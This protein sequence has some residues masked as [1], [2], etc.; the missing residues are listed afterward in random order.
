MQVLG[1]DRSSYVRGGERLFLRSGEIHYFRVPRAEWRDRLAKFKASGG[2]CVA[3]YVPW[4]IHEP[5][6]GRF[7]FADP[8]LD[9]EAFLRLCDEMGLWVL[10]RPGPYQYSELSYDGLPGWLCENYPELRARNV[11]GKDF[12]VSSISY[13][14]PQF[15]AKARRWF[16]EVVPRLARHQTTRGGAVAAVQLDNELMG[17]HEWFGSWDYH[18]EAMGLGREEGRWPEFLR[19]R[20]GSLAALNEAWDTRLES[21]AKAVPATA[22]RDGRSGE[23]R[24]VKDYQDCYFA[25]IADFAETLAQWLRAEGIEVPLV[26]NSANPYMNSYF[27]ETVARLGNSQFLLGSDHYY[28]LSQDWDQNNPTP[29]YAT[30]CFYSNEMLR[31]YGFPPTIFELPGGSLSDFPPITASDA[32]CCYLLNVALGMK[33]YNYYIFTGGV[34]RPNTG[35]TGEL[36]DYGAALSPTGE[37]RPLYYAQQELA[38][39][40]EEH[41]WLAGAERVGDCRLGLV[42]EYSRAG[43]Y[44]AGTEGLPFPCEEA[45]TFMRKGAMMTAFCASASP[46]LADLDSDSLLADLQTPLLVPAASAMPA[47]VQRR[48]V[49]FLEAGGKLLLTP[50]VPTLDEHFRPCRILADFLGA[51][52]EPLQAMAPLLAAFGVRNVFVNGGLLATPQ[53][54]AGATVTAVEE[55]SGA[56][57]GWEQRLPGGGVASVLGVHWRQAKREHEEMLRRALA[58]LGWQARVRGDNPNVWTSLRS[59]GQRSMLFLMNLFTAPMTVRAEFCDPATG[60]WVDTGVHRL[61]PISVQMWHNGRSLV[62]PLPPE[63]R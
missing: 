34:N 25:A 5:E 60:A 52:Q 31:H 17:I 53:V 4:L 55:R 50:A 39:F 63:A 49:R 42:W 30:K 9:V 10:V 8:Q 15:L 12:R 54:P 20:Y 27:R 46:I 19:R 58:S 44:G 24:Q 43:R 57:I 41:A 37:I 7:D 36:Y 59:D 3:T 56:V 35:T 2:N 11:Q 61:P 51:T 18:P 32:L 21:W 28:S 26:H 45:W 1:F 38:K 33:G 14:H 47:D 16:G 40:L 23:R 6:E 48:L 22:V 13:L 29:Q 62:L